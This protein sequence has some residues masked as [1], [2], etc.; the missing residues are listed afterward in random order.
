MVPPT[1]VD[2]ENTNL[3]QGGQTSY[4]DLSAHR[5]HH[6]DQLSSEASNHIVAYSKAYCE[7]K[8]KQRPNWL[9]RPCT[10]THT[11]TYKQAYPIAKA[12]SHARA[13]PL[14]SW[15]IGPWKAVPERLHL[16]SQWGIQYAYP[17]RKYDKNKECQYQG[18]NIIMAIWELHLTCGGIGPNVAEE[19]IPP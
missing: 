12:I 6:T 1:F 17:I 13:P 19:P 11:L 3:L 7:S 5:P 4:T 9:Q 16:M 2:A 14:D 8:R 15:I 10:R 18:G